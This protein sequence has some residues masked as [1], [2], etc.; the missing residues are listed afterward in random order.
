MFNQNN[1]PLEHLAAHAL[2]LLTG[3]L[4]VI[5]AQAY[6][7]WMRQR[8]RADAQCGATSQTGKVAP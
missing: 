5:G 2:A 7:A 4:C 8:G 6:G 1:G 3:A